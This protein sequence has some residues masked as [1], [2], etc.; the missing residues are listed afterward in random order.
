MDNEPDDK[1][2]LCLDGK[3]RWV[4]E[5][6]LYRNMTIPLLLIKVLLITIAI[7]FALIFVIC[8]ASG[9]DPVEFIAESAVPLLMIM[10]I[11]FPV[12]VL[13]YLLYAVMNGGVYCVLFEMDD[14]G[15]LHAQQ[16]RQ[17][18]K[19][20]LLADIS[21][22]AGLATG[23]VGAVGRGLLVATNTEKYTEFGGVRKLRAVPG[24]NVIY[25]DT[26]QVY[27][28]DSDF[29]FVWNYIKDRCPNASVKG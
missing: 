4:Y 8:V 28:S 18:K 3:Y 17:V 9:D 29:E 11:F 25:I 6:S 21:V 19:A 27:A 26:N 14:K 15:V 16:D 13:G 24:R 23:N 2:Q 22:L 20:K 5:M 7:C 10:A 1:A 12:C